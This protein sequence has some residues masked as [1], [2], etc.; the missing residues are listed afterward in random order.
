MC[1]GNIEYQYIAFRLLKVIIIHLEK[2]KK[3]GTTF[4]LWSE[5]Y[6]HIMQV[7]DMLILQRL[8]S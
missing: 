2:R 3:I 7:N 1:Q 8:L 4:I 5:V 6:I